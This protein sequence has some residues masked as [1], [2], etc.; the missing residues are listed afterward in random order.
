MQEL[1][2]HYP[3]YDKDSGYQEADPLRWKAKPFKLLPMPSLPETRVRK[4][5]VFEQIGLDYLG[6]LSIK[7][8]LNKEQ[9]KDG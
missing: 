8:K 6:P 7:T 2:I 9:L 4:S 3:N 5:R 1:V